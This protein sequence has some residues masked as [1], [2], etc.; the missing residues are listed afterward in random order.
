MWLGWMI[1]MAWAVVPVD[2]VGRP[3]ADGLGRLRYRLDAGDWEVERADGSVRPSPW[4]NLP[5]DFALTSG[6]VDFTLQGYTYQS[7]GS[8]PSAVAIG[9]VT[10]DGRNDVVLVTEAHFD[11]TNDYHVF[12]FA[13]TST[14]TLA[15]PVSYPY[16]ATANYCGLV[17]ADLNEDGTLDVVVGHDSGVAVLLSDGAGGLVEGVGQ[18]VG[19]SS[20]LVA[21]DVDLDG[22]VDV[23]A[24]GWFSDAVVLF[25]DGAGGLDRHQ[26]YEVD[27]SGR[28]EVDL[29]DVDGDGF[30]DLVLFTGNQNGFPTAQ[31]LLHDRV[32]SFTV[33]YADAPVLG[34]GP[35]GGGVGQ[36][37][38]VFGADVIVSRNRNSPT[39]LTLM[40][41]DGTG[42]LVNPINLPSYDLPETVIVFDI[43]HNGYDDVI[44][45]HGGWN[46]VGVYLQDA[47][48]LA[49]EVL[50]TI[51]Y[52]SNYDSQGVA[53]GDFTG[54][55]CGDV[56]IADYNAGL[57]TLVGVCDGDGDSD[58]LADPVDP[59]P[60]LPGDDADA[61]GDGLGDLCDACPEVP[62]G[63]S[64]DQDGDGAGD[65]CD[66]C[67][68]VPDDGADLDGDGVGDACDV[69]PEVEDPDQPDADGD[70]LGDA[71]DP[72]PSL[73]DDGSDLD[74]DG[75]GDACDVCPGVV[76]PD[77]SD[78]D[79]DGLG[80]AC[81][82]CP[83]LF[84]DGSDLDGDGQGDACD[85]CPEVD[86]P[87]QSDA[88]ADGAG[89]LCDNCIAR[90]NEDQLDVDL[91]GLGDLCDNCPEVFTEPDPFN[92]I[93]ADQ[94]DSDVDGLGDL[95][96][97]C[98]FL[99]N[100]GQED[101]DGDGVGD[102]CDLCEGFDDRVDADGD[103]LPDACDPCPALAGDGA[104]RDGD[105]LGDACDLCPDTADDGADGDE[106]G[107]GDACDPCPLVS[108]DGA[109]GDG[110]GIPDACDLCPALA[111]DGTD[112][113]GDGTPDAC[114]LCPG[115][116]DGVDSDDDGTPDACD[117]CPDVPDPDQYDSD[118][119][120]YGNVCDRC[121]AVVDDQADADGDG[122][123]DACD[124]CPTVS[125]ADNT[126]ED[127]DGYAT[128]CDCAPDDPARAEDC[129]DPVVDE[130]TGCS[131][132]QRQGGVAWGGLVLLGALLRRRR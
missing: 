54:D 105:G 99:S 21:T 29:G 116:D 65:A 52:A 11:P 34:Y 78:A 67:P 43:D 108:N 123:G 2:V 58:G 6:A 121:Q 68:E 15:A 92:N 45:P 95:C 111:D 72:C 64:R 69:C 66:L 104:D 19:E 87:N 117:V 22:H 90:V 42:A 125:S 18:A 16:N 37:D 40:T 110:D 80:N 27:V 83:A 77:Q 53:A 128:P 103:D 112:G 13:Q 46:R 88:D 63:P 5:V 33:P 47:N 62:G 57:V 17:L 9:D 8:S 44:T 28:E 74:G 23:A 10:G 48:G 55:G 36:L 89:D 7:V 100:V 32:G 129:G 82:P 119:D 1:G 71:C 50:Y 106:D 124:L 30:L 127:D 131:C 38:D 118:G 70:G 75:L 96:D 113:D 120:G 97:N 73:V 101:L 94:A 126:D 24:A 102:V 49:A 51:P 79:G 85:V 130:P 84:D 76:N 59:C 91:D 61:D 12:V 20:S 56:A 60:R 3:L 25:G 115:G 26:T 4:V 86:D 107:L 41:S 109:D 114:D 14:G 39:W 35:R 122:R 93:Q 98:P 132:D 31:T 81:D